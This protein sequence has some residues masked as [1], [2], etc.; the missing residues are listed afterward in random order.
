MNQHIEFR[1]INKLALLLILIS[2]LLS[3]ISG[4]SSVLNHSN[5][6]PLFIGGFLLLI[7]L[8]LIFLRWPV[9][10]L[11]AAIFVLLFPTSL[12]P[13]WLS[14]ILNR[15]LTLLAFIF[16]VFNSIKS[17][18]RMIW[19]PTFILMLCFIIWSV[20]TLMWAPSLSIGR[21]ALARYIL[22]LVLFLFLIPNEINSWAN[23]N[24]LMKVLAYSGWLFVIIGISTLVLSGYEIGSRLG[25]LGGNENTLGELYPVAATGVIWLVLR[26]PKRLKTIRFFFGL[27]F[28]IL[29]FILIALSGSR[30]SLITWFVIMLFY[31]FWKSTRLWGII[32]LVVL[33]LAIVGGSFLLETTFDRF[34]NRTEDTLLGGREALWKGTW[35]LIRDYPWKGVGI[36]NVS[37]LAIPYIQYF[38][39]VYKM[40][41]I[42]IH[43]PILTIWAETGIPGILLYLGVLM[44]ALWSFVK[45]V[46]RVSISQLEPLLIYFSLVS[47][48]FVGFLATWFKGGG[49]EFGYVSFLMIALLVIPANLEIKTDANKAFTD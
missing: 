39:S 49:A 27:V 3:F 38:R 34:I 18:R 22:R 47:S 11:Y 46:R 20:F 9:L 24:G 4:T 17:H 25:V 29:S 19:T 31:I 35:Q 41:S 1:K 30:G 45:Q 21:D 32:G 36:G 48:A 26:S 13:V 40:E 28:S 43:N 16:W 7:I 44:S 23:L 10:A 2:L 15:S 37:I 42:S 6:A 14:P 5:F 8:G 33:I 12:V